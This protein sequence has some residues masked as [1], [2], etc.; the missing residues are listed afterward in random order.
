VLLAG[1]ASQSLLPDDDRI[2]L[3]RELPGRTFYLRESMYVGPFWSDRH[4][5]LLSDVVPGEIPYLTSPTGAVVDPGK[6]QAIVPAGTRV[7]VVTLEMPTAFAVTTRMPLSPRYNPWLVLQVEGLPMEPAPTLVLRRDLRSLD[8]ARADVDRY[9]SPEDL[10]AVLKTFP[11]AV[12]RAVKEKRVIEGMPAEAVR[13]A[14]GMPEKRTI[15]A[16]P[17]GRREQWVWPSEK[18][19]ATLVDG[20]L[21]LFIGDAPSLPVPAAENGG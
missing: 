20:R 19:K 9:L 1:C 13:M 2:R 6:P 8:E 7:R 18:R 4:K 15:T 17:E 12:L 5:V 21:S 14:W 10:E 3:E 11:E 16:S